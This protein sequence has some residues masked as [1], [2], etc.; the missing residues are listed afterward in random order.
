MSPSESI[1][2]LEFDSQRQQQA[3]ALVGRVEALENRIHSSFSADEH[4]QYFLTNG[5]RRING[6]VIIDY[7][8]T[9]ALHVRKNN[10]GGDV[11]TVNTSTAGVSLAGT[12]GVTGNTTITGTVGIT[13]NTTITGKLGIGAA[14]TDDAIVISYAPQ[15]D[16]SAFGIVM[17]YTPNV[18]TTGAYYY[19]SLHLN[20]SPKV[21][22]GQTNTG[23]NY[24]YAVDLIGYE[25]LLNGTLAE[26]TGF[27]I[28][29]GIIGGVGTI[30]T[31]R[32]IFIQ[33]YY[34]TGTISNYYGIYIAA[35]ATGGTIT[36]EYS[37]YI[38]DDAL[39]YWVG[40]ISALSITDR[41][42]FYE[43]DALK[44]IKNIKGKNGEIDHST[45]PD[46]VKETRKEVVAKKSIQRKEKIGKSDEEHIESYK[47]GDT[48]HGGT[49]NFEKDIDFEEVEV[50]ERNL[51][52]MVS[53]LTVAVQQLTDEVEEIKNAP[54]N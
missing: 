26:V 48:I 43:G 28:Q 1:G 47:K 21:S 25:N 37:M 15:N 45:L 2:S 17:N 7:T 35:P 41:T 34:T 20:H 23:Y 32:G 39:S 54:K 18:T 16:S 52:N 53:M 31:C 30:T 27:N 11:F 10:D 8:G 49:H 22:T 42:P 6:Q 5:S 40:G 36:N 4:K 51:S 19:S 29:V 33:P 24:G 9:E 13:G 12:L 14:P 50:T 46:F 3:I 38:A 44:E